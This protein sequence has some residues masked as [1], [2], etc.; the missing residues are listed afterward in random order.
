MEIWLKLLDCDCIKI[1]LLI[2]SVTRGHYI[3]VVPLLCKL[4]NVIFEINSN[5]SYSCSRVIK[6]CYVCHPSFAF[7]T[8]I[9]ALLT[10]D[11]ISSSNALR[12][13][14]GTFGSPRL[15]AVES[16]SPERAIS[17]SNS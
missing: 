3:T 13:S 5:A 2:L 7:F 15:A 17:T 12:S 8:N 6:R 16:S 1:P 11:R 14:S 9:L 10:N 4:V